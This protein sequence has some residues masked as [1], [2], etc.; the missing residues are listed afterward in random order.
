MSG[1]GTI[2]IRDPALARE[3][4]ELAAYYTV[5]AMDGLEGAAD[6]ARVW[7]NVAEALK[8]HLV[9]PASAGRR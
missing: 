8:R 5:E 3:L 2:P 6:G 4:A 9:P 7:G 1:D